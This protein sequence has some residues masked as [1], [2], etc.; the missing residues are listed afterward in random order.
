MAF[1]D[2]PSHPPHRG[3]MKPILAFLL[4]ATPL[5]AQTSRALSW[6]S[7]NTRVIHAQPVQVTQV[8]TRI[9]IADQLATTTLDIALRNP[10]PRP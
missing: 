7:P 9:D 8:E 3:G 5:L 10:T 4:L 1:T 2:A 6:I